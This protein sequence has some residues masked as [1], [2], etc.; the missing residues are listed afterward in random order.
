MSVHQLLCLKIPA[1]KKQRLN[2]RKIADGF[3]IEC[4]TV[5]AARPHGDVVEYDMLGVDSTIRHH[6]EASITQRKGLFPCGGR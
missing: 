6:A 5:F 4:F 2:F 3:L 1:G